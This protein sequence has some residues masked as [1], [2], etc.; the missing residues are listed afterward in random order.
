MPRLH[1]MPSR[2]PHQSGHPPPPTSNQTKH[3]HYNRIYTTDKKHSRSNSRRQTPPPFGIQDLPI[4]ERS[5]GSPCDVKDQRSGT[6]RTTTVQHRGY[7]FYQSSFDADGKGSILSVNRDAAGTTLTYL[8]YALLFLSMVLIL[9]NRE[10]RFVFLLKKFASGSSRGVVCLCL[11]LSSQSL[12]ASILSKDGATLDREQADRFA[13]LWLSYQ[14]RTCPMQ[15]LSADFTMKLT[16]KSSYKYADAQQVMLGWLFF[17]EKWQHVPLFDLEHPELKALIQASGKATFAH[18]FSADKQYRLEA[19]Q[20]EMFSPGKQT[21]L[22]KEASRLDEK[23]QLIAMLQQGALLKLFPLANASG[24]VHWYAATD[25]LPENTG[26]LEALF[27]RNFFPMYYE[28]IQQGYREK[29]LLLIDKLAAFQMREGGDLIPSPRKMEIELLYNRAQLFSFLFKWNLTAGALGMLF[30]LFSFN[31]TQRKPWAHRLFYILL[32]CSFLFTTTGLL[33]RAYIG[34]RIPLSNGY[35]TMLFIAWTV[36]LVGILCRS[37][38]FLL[39]NFSFLLS[40]FCLLVA[41]IG[42][43]NPAITPLVPVLQLPLLS[44]HVSLIMIA[45]ALCGF[46]VLNSLTAFVLRIPAFAHTGASSTVLYLK[47]LSE[48]FMYPATFLLGA[49]IFVG[50]IWA[51]V[52]W[53]RYWGWDPKE[54]WALI[55]FLLMSFSFHGKTLSWFN[56]PLF[57]H[58]FVLLVFASVLMT[59]FGV[60][61]LLGGMHSYGG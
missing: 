1:S 44:I 55:T 26:K 47:E 31:A 22:G 21:P 29:A 13:H 51:N 9:I 12:S 2:H 17:P 37:R 8:S 36:L 24:Q 33:A 10:G 56:R 11:F 7:R 57:Y 35:E 4:R 58:F 27:V 34:G 39:T 48:L 16:G 54:T 45:Y 6:L 19:Y 49:G 53:G 5:C 42:S 38:A 15:T 50:A 61:H 20:K 40:G 52:S 59:Y 28:C 46:M 18:F 43:M 3:G 14:G 32:W 30:F 23:I 60:N 41:H 25:S